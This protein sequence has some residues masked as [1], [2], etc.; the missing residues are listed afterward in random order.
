M[1]AFFSTWDQPFAKLLH[2]ADGD[3]GDEAGAIRWSEIEGA[4]WTIPA[5]RH[6]TGLAREIPLTRSP[7]SP[8]R[9]GLASSA[10]SFAGGM[11][12]IPKRPC[13]RRGDSM[14]CVEQ[15]DR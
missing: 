5:A 3:A 4:T 2:P 1:I 12:A 9:R 8:A 7:C 14:T 15:H 11:A 10:P 13:C 6:K